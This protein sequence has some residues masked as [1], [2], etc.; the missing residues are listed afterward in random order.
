[1]LK[2][3]KVLNLWNEYLSKQPSSFS[4]IDLF[5][6]KIFFL[7]K[8]S[9]YIKRFDNHELEAIV[10]VNSWAHFRVHTYLNV[11]GIQATLWHI[12][13]VIYKRYL[14]EISYQFKR[15]PHSCFYSKE[16]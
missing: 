16:L 4:W 6:Y 7:K 15:K 10:E 13:F 2:P 11:K 8:V 3:I 9:T 12:L 14:N 1:M 5:L